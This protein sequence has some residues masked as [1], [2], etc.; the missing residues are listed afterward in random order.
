MFFLLTLNQGVF[1][2]AILITALVQNWYLRIVIKY[3]CIH[4][5]DAKYKYMTLL[6]CRIESMGQL[7]SDGWALNASVNKQLRNCIMVVWYIN[8]IY[9]CRLNMWVWS[10]IL[11]FFQRQLHVMDETYV[12]NQ[13]KEDVCYVSQDFYKDMQIA[14]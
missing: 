5:D 6:M 7:R 1:L 12:I 11:H 8:N 4:S 9:S 3:M 13:V 14:Q 2:I 10:D